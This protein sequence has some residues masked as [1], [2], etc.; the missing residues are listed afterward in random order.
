MILY[1]DAGML[2]ET[3]LPAAPMSRAPQA[4][5]RNSPGPRCIDNPDGRADRAEKADR[6]DR[7]ERVGRVCMVYRGY[8]TYFDAPLFGVMW[9]THSPIYAIGPHGLPAGDPSKLED[10]AQRQRLTRC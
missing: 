3:N 5:R 6:A 10:F 9:D 2:N 4:A 7:A 1:C 8:K